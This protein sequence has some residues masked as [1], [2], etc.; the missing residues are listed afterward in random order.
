MMKLTTLFRAQ[1]PYH[2]PLPRRCMAV[3]ATHTVPVMFALWAM[4]QLG[5]PINSGLEFSI[6]KTYL[7]FQEL[8]GH[9]GVSHKGRNFGPAPWLPVL[10]GFELRSDDHQKHH[11]QASC[12]FSK[13]FSLFDKLF[14]TWSPA[15]R[16]GRVGSMQKEKGMWHFNYF[17]L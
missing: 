2:L 11:I 12:N 1:N 14:G 9:A 16:V 7:L 17:S 8:Y 15:D 6:A 13:R 4:E 5:L 10:L 3:L